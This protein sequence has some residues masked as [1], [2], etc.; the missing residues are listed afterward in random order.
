[1][2]AVFLPPS[3]ALI[4]SEPRGCSQLRQAEWQTTALHQ[5]CSHSPHPTSP[6]P[7]PPGEK[8][9][10]CTAASWRALTMATQTKVLWLLCNLAPAVKARISSM[11]Q[12]HVHVFNMI[13]KCFHKHVV[14]WLQL[15]FSCETPGS[16]W[17]IKRQQPLLEETVALCCFEQQKENDIPQSL[18]LQMFRASHQVN[19]YRKHK[20]TGSTRAKYNGETM[21]HVC[22]TLETTITGAGNTQQQEVKY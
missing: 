5:A 20:E 2:C 18:W 10:S 17:C 13:K 22:N 3:A 7:H 15:M 21:R 19:F 1:M 4:A 11:I 8:S 14:V 12:F 16:V 6:P 9:S